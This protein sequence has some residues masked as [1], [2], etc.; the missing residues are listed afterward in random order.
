VP[1]AQVPQTQKREEAPEEVM[2]VAMPEEKPLLASAAPESTVPAQQQGTSAQ[3]YS[4]QS[5]T[6]LEALRKKA[7]EEIA[8]TT[9][10]TSSEREFASVE[11]KSGKVK[12][13][14]LISK[15]LQKVGGSKVS[16]ST[17]YDVDGEMM[18]YDFK[19]G[20]ITIQKK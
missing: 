1:V 14:G 13:L 8:K 3:Q 17:A 6:V 11:G 18:A 7:E 2:P 15:G 20:G 4:A 5:M 9:G 12:V 19:A 10:T 16:L